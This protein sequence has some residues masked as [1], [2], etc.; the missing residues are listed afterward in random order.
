MARSAKEYSEMKKL[1]VT[2]LRPL[3]LLMSYKS[4]NKTFHTNE[5]E[6][7]KLTGIDIST[8]TC[9]ILKHGVF[10]TEHFAIKNNEAQAKRKS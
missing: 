2:P 10:E 1:T 3:E 8:I 5:I 7:E 9:E 4:H 6:A